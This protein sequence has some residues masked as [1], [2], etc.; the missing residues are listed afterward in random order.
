MEINT[1]YNIQTAQGVSSA[2][3]ST[4][5]N[6]YLQEL[7]EKYPTANITAQ[8]FNSEKAF[9]NYAFGSI[10]S[11]NNVA[12]A[13]N[14]LKQMA[15]DPAI[16]EKYETYIKKLVDC[17]QESKDYSARNGGELL[18]HGVTIDK[19]GKVNFWSISR[20]VPQKPTYQ[21]RMKKLLDEKLEQHVELKKQRK[22]EEAKEL[23][24]KHIHDIEDKKRAEVSEVE[25]YMNVEI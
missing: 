14:I 9:S 1:N 24:Q 17:E 13:P 7:R 16:A 6:T 2:N 12:I 3:K 8:A 22:A 4:N 20:A 11:F 21:E 25:H 18:A 10:G 15:D 23:E 5:S 19:N